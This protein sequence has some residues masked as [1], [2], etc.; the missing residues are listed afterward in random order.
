MWTYPESLNAAAFAKQA[1]SLQ[2]SVAQQIERHSI[3]VPKY[4]ALFAEVNTM[5]VQAHAL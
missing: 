1:E 5:A 2:S 4:G 3:N